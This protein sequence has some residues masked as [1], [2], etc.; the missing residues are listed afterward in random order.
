MTITDVPPQVP[1]EEDDDSARRRSIRR[2]FRRAP[3]P[4]VALTKEPGTEVATRQPAG[5]EIAEA[6]AWVEKHALKLPDSRHVKARVKHAAPKLPGILLKLTVIKLPAVIWTE[7]IGPIWI[8]AGKCIV[9]YK[10]WVSAGMLDDAQKAAEGPLRARQ[11]AD[12]HRAN[13]HRVYATLVGAA[14]VAG[15]AV[16]TYYA[17][18]TV[19]YVAVFI[20]LGILDVIGRSGREPTKK[21]LAP[22][23]REPIHE[24][25]SYRQLTASIQAAFNECI[26]VDGDGNPLVR[27]DGVCAMDR[28]RDE[29][30]QPISTY[31]EIKREHVEYVERAIGARLR[32]VK[33]LEVPSSA[34]RRILVIRHG[35]P[36]VDVPCAPDDPAGSC[37]ITDPAP[38]GASKDPDRSFA[39]GIAGVHAIIVATTGGGKTVHFDNL[40]DYVSKCRNA[41]AWGINIAKRHAFSKWR[42]CIQKVGRNPDEAAEV[43]DAALAEIQRRLDILDELIQSDDPS[44]HTEKWDPDNP[45]MGPALVIFIDEYAQLSKFNG[46]PKGTLNLLEKVEDIGRLGREVMVSFVLAFQKWGNADAGSTVI[47]S[48]STVVICG[49]C[50][51]DD[52]GD[53]FGYK[54]RD[55]AGW[56]P[57]LLKPA[58]DYGINDAGKAF[59]LAPGF[60]PDEV[61]GWRPRSVTDTIR[62]ANERVRQG[63]PKLPIVDEDDGG[64]EEAVLVPETLFALEEA[65]NHFNPKDG[66]LP[67]KVAAEWISERTGMKLTQP[68]LASALKKELG[69][70]EEGLIPATRPTRNELGGNCNCYS[71]DDVRAALGAL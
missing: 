2:W 25:I 16:Y 4:E 60:G 7:G 20:L 32:T 37:S 66:W 57:H 69:H 50:S 29:W 30:R 40:I 22:A 21:D 49:P 24:G 39:L 44:V 27:C 28:D 71:A 48:Q 9:A 1:P 10:G 47:S 15:S 33:L 34:T 23:Y 51:S 8:G 36:L 11:K 17:H 12:Q 58:N 35:D 54:A 45:R 64:I 63:L 68:A 19:F 26:G 41:V 65:F 38:L 14:I 67:S 13:G 61:R 55:H 18:S 43:L 53:I 52:A 42:G 70:L 6:W 56:T 59:V 46:V 5:E 62:I 31:Q 3:G